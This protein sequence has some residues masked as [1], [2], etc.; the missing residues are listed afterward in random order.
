[1]AD[2]NTEKSVD[3]Q[4]KDELDNINNPIWLSAS[5]GALLLGVRKKTIKRAIKS[6]KIKYKIENRKYLINLT[7]LL[8]LA[9]ENKRLENK[10]YQEGLGQ[11]LKDKLKM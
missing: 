9:H 2:K 1:M 10:F 8:R 11:Y 4:K 3:Y 6:G 7:S 5:Q